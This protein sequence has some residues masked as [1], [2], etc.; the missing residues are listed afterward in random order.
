LSYIKYNQPYKIMVKN[1]TGGSKTKGQARKFVNAPRQ[2]SNI[3][4]ANDENE[5]YAQVTKMLGNGMCHVLCIDGKTR[6][7]HIRGKFRGRGKRD[8][9]IGNNSWLLIGLRDWESDKNDIKL[10]NCD[11]L[12]VYSPI[13]IDRLKSTVNENWSLFNNDNGKKV[14]DDDVLF[15]DERTDEYMKLVE[16]ELT[17]N[18]IN[19]NDKKT[20]NIVFNEEEEINVDDI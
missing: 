20:L 8:N 17:Q 18:Q 6:L 15:I 9:L 1:T 16:N 12:E 10:N 4:L 11:L 5:L 7:C 2:T 14:S 13:D 19:S 3:R